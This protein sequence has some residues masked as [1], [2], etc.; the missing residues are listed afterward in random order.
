MGGLEAIKWLAH[1]LTNHQ[2][3]KQKEEVTL[4]DMTAENHRKQIDWLEERIAQRDTTIDTLQTELRKEQAEKLEWINRCH[5]TE[6]SLKELEIKRCDTR[7]CPHRKPP[8]D[9]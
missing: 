2:T 8:S 3:D 1:F 7:G 5:E 9:Y 4:N 6:L